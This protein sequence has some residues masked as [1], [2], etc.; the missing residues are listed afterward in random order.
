[1][2]TLKE[3]CK[4]IYT[5]EQQQQ[6]RCTNDSGNNNTNNIEIVRNNYSSNNYNGNRITII[7]KAKIA[8]IDLVW[9]CMD[10]AVSSND[11]RT[12]KR[13]RKKNVFFVDTYGQGTVE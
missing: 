10:H 1:M 7:I 5:V 6:Q 3:N 4:H 8:R 11:E 9:W 13:K 2:H 12:Y